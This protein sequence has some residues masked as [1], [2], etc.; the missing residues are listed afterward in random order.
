VTQRR[1]TIPRQ[2][3]SDEPSQPPSAGLFD[4]PDYDLPAIPRHIGSIDDDTLMETFVQFTE[5]LNYVSVEMAQAEVE[6]EKTEAALEFFKAKGMALNWDMDGKKDKKVTV[7]RARMLASPEYQKLQ[8]DY[9][10]AYAR[11]KMTAA[12]CAG[13]E[14]SAAIMSRELSR[15][16]GAAGGERR[17]S[18]WTP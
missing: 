2:S 7:A 3:E 5:W 11:R 9:L 10:T 12:I 4:K 17:A 14:R 16:I 1:R 8:S 6:E 15:R 18:R 13:C